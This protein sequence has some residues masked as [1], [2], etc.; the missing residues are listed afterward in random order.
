[1]VEQVINKVREPPNPKKI[2]R[3][4][5]ELSHQCDNVLKST[6]ILGELLTS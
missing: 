3:A 5:L 2:Y 4:A 1:M 6:Q